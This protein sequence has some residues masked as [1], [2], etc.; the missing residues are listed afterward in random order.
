NMNGSVTYKRKTKTIDTFTGGAI[1]VIPIGSSQVLEVDVS[2]VVINRKGDGYV[3]KEGTGTFT[4]K[5][6]IFL[7]DK[8]G[9]AWYVAAGATGRLEVANSDIKESSGEVDLRVRNPEGVDVFHVKANTSFAIDKKGTVK[10][11]VEGKVDANVLA[12]LTL[13]KGLG[14]DKTWTAYLSK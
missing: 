7:Y 2:N 4:A 8:G 5:M 6:P 3:V 1:I 12:D 13:G 9:W 14:P 11:P 10:K